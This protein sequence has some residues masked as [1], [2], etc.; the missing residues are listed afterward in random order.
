MSEQIRVAAFSPHSKPKR[1]LCLAMRSEGKILVRSFETWGSVNIPYEPYRV[2]ERLKMLESRGFFILTDSTHELWE[3]FPSVDLTAR[4]YSRFVNRDYA[5]DQL[6]EYHQ[7]G[8]LTL[9][10]DHSGIIPGP[11][12]YR[13]EGSADGTGAYQFRNYRIELHILLIATLGLLHPP[14]ISENWISTYFEDVPLGEKEPNNPLKS[15]QRITSQLD[16]EL[17]NQFSDKS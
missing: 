12:D 15:F 16:A 11:F 3:Q 4:K 13:R 6:I 8:N 7:A 2:V 1:F 10:E 14:T 9:P 5:L 17:A